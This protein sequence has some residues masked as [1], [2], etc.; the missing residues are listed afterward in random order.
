MLGTFK[1]HFK[2]TYFMDI[3]G[4]EVYMRQVFIKL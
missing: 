2:K 4:K 1:N 3:T